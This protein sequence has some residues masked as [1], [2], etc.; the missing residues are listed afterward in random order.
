MIADNQ[1]K[2]KW[3]NSQCKM[4][5]QA[6]QSALKNAELTT[7]RDGSH[8]IDKNSEETKEFVSRK[9]VF[10]ALKEYTLTVES[11][12]TSTIKTNSQVNLLPKN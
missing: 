4:H 3:P 5:L 12:S 11:T 1:Y 2:K 6:S 10:R 7:D 9:N 8:V